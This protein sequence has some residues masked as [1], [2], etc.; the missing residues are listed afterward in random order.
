MAFLAWAN[1]VFNLFDFG[2]S[3]SYTRN[4]PIIFANQNYPSFA[5]SL[6]SEKNEL[7]TQAPVRC[8][9]TAGL[10]SGAATKSWLTYSSVNP[11]SL[12]RGT[13][14]LSLRWCFMAR[15]KSKGQELAPVPSSLLS[16]GTVI[17][18][19]QS[20]VWS[21]KLAQSKLL[22]STKKTMVMCPSAFI[23]RNLTW[24]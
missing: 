19:T 6:H 8:F 24:R 10:L 9:F 14:W 17:V 13:C 23:D 12:V 16:R 18:L 11:E 22:L 20:E 15:E 7:S 3:F 5:P 1:M 21:Y 4:N 2:N